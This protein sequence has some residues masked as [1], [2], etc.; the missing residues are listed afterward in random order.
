MVNRRRIEGGLR[1]DGEDGGVSEGGV[2]VRVGSVV[3]GSIGGG[4]LE[5]SGEER[6]GERARRGE[7]EIRN[8]C[9]SAC[10][11]EAANTVARV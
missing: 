1:A 9:V 6:G 3:H 11:L 4:S 10:W 7:E 5:R 8:D 2:E